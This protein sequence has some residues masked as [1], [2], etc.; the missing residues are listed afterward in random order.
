[1][2]NE[3]LNAYLGQLSRDDALEFK[4]RYNQMNAKERQVLIHQLSTQFHEIRNKNSTPEPGLDMGDLYADGGEFDKDKMFVP[5]VQGQEVTYDGLV[6]VGQQVYLVENENQ[7]AVQPQHRTRGTSSSSRSSRS[8]GVRPSPTGYVEPRIR[9]NITGYRFDDPKGIEESVEKRLVQA[10]PEDEP[11]LYYLPGTN[12]TYQKT[13]DGQFRKM[14]PIYREPPASLRERKEAQDAPE[15]DV[16]DLVRE[17]NRQ[18]MP[19]NAPWSLEIPQQVQHRRINSFD[20]EPTRED[21]P[22][23]LSDEILGRINRSDTP[24]RLIPPK[25]DL[26][27]TGQNRHTFVESFN[28]DGTP[29]VVDRRFHTET[30]NQG[31][32]SNLES[33]RRALMNTSPNQTSTTRPGDLI[34]QPPGTRTMVP[35]GRGATMAGQERGSFFPEYDRINSSPET[36]INYQNR[37]EVL[38]LLQALETNR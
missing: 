8:T 10:Y 35:N 21:G 29:N 27:N 11:D 12:A 32:N 26:S 34:N 22:R 15:Y 17:Q 6:P 33:Y 38:R 16:M 36:T 23:I 9:G 4:N 25:I 13:S 5:K 18:G 31:A 7:G 2:R 14:R 19:A 3:L 30:L 20:G 1:M 28:D 37:E 24:D